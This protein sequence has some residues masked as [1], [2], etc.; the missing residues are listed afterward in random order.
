LGLRRTDWIAVVV[1]LQED[2]YRFSEA[3]AS[4]GS[5]NARSFN[6]EPEALEWLT[7]TA[8]PHTPV[9]H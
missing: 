6:D 8:L 7:G 9:L 5:W 2:V 4:N 3:V 1:K